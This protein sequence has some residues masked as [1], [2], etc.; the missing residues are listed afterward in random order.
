MKIS[1][2]H[3]WKTVNEAGRHQAELRNQN[4]HIGRTMRELQQQSEQKYNNRL[5]RLLETLEQ[6]ERASAK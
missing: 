1:S 3:I 6:T 2:R 4:L 5:Q